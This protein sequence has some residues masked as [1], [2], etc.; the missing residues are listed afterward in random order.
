MKT[1]WLSTLLWEHLNSNAK[2]LFAS[3]MRTKAATSLATEWI[4]HMLS[5]W[6]YV[7]TEF[8]SFMREV[9]RKIVF[10]VRVCFILS[11]I[12]KQ[13]K[14]WSELLRELKKAEDISIEENSKEEAEQEKG[15]YKTAKVTF[16]MASSK[17]VFW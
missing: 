9:G 15:D 7:G 10:Q 1:T 6:K 16:L 5:P 17:K 8:C 13:M 14:K 4:T 11:H 2:Y 3:T 12:Q